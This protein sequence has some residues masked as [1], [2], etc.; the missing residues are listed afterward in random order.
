VD[1]AATEAAKRDGAVQA[2]IAWRWD[3]VE[4]DPHTVRP[5]E[6]RRHGRAADTVR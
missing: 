4:L 6:M 3:G 1:W 2:V 5:D